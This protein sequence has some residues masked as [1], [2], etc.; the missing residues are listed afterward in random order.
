MNNATTLV[1]RHTAKLAQD[2]PE[3]SLAEEFN[4]MYRD[5]LV[6]NRKDRLSDELSKMVCALDRSVAERARAYLITSHISRSPEI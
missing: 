4:T 3:V 2:Q 5:A 1:S 6:R